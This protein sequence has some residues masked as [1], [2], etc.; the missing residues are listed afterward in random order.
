MK[1]IICGPS[2]SGKSFLLKFLNID[3]TTNDFDVYIELNQKDSTYN[4]FITWLELERDSNLLVMSNH[5]HLLLSILAKKEEINKKGYKFVFLRKPFEEIEANLK[6]EN[7]DGLFHPEDPGAV[8]AIKLHLIPL[9]ERLADIVVNT[10]NNE[11]E[12]SAEE[13]RALSSD[14]YLTQQEFIEQAG[15]INAKSIDMVHWNANRWIYHQRSIDIL[16]KI[17]GQK[18]LEIGTMGI[19]LHGDS[20]TM[21]FNSEAGWPTFE[22]DF[23]H[24]ARI[25]PWPFKD[26][27]YDCV[28]ALRVFHHLYPT[29]KEAFIE[30]KRVGKNILLVIPAKYHDTPHNSRVIS[31]QEFES[32]NDGKPPSIIDD[33]GHGVVYFWSSQDLV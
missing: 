1:F 14:Q 19:K 17:S 13:V 5:D 4:E 25:T 11:L 6:K 10:S 16:R 21:D 32:W 22:T 2:G 18:F 23:F 29:Q 12:K 27:M 26:K 15:D 30:A 9:Y 31:L 7:V 33:T 3:R 24:D 28:I 20:Q 8:E